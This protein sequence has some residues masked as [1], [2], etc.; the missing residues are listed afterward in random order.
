MTPT[1]M[2]PPV[3][4]RAL[5]GAITLT[6]TLT[7][8]GLAEGQEDLA[9]RS[10][11]GPLSPGI[12]LASHRGYASFL[13]GDLE[14]LGWEVTDE[15]GRLVARW[16]SEGPLVEIFIDVPFLLWDGDGVH[17]ADAPYRADGEI[18]LPVQLL[19]DVLPWKLPGAFGY[20]AGS[21]VLEIPAQPGESTPPSGPPPDPTRVVI[22]DAGHGGRDP[23]T[24]G[25][26][27]TQEKEVALGIARALSGILE[28]EEKIKLKAIFYGGDDARDHPATHLRET[29][30]SP[31]Q[32]VTNLSDGKVQVEATVKDTSQLRW[33]LQGFGSLVE[34]VGP[35]GLREEMAETA[36]KMAGRYK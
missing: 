26:R 35:N 34:V 2:N 23:G 28:G 9:L 20:E 4:S 18:Y 6:L 33:W 32:R 13:A 31:D 11:S 3:L 25:P 29:P 7:L 1:S 16:G 27:G 14:R 21:W 17:L 5:S 12:S 19:V 30:L 15:E 24:V 10:S 36:Q 22:I 8:F